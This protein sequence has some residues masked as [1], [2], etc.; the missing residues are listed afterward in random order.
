MGRVDTYSSYLTQWACNKSFRIQA[1]GYSRFKI[2]TYDSNSSRPMLRTYHVHSLSGPSR[3]PDQAIDILIPPYVYARSQMQLFV[4]LN[5]PHHRDN[6]LMRSATIS[7]RSHLERATRHRGVPGDI[8]SFLVHAQ[9]CSENHKQ[10]YNI[11][12]PI[13]LRM[14]QSDRVPPPLFFS[15]SFWTP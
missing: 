4:S 3:R 15:L 13:R 2:I 8:L 10:Q 1:L 14:K 11:R 9:I 12:T 7:H 6:N 5:L